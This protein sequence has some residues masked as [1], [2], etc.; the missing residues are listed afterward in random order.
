MSLAG[1]YEVL[2]T[3]NIIS[4]T[5]IATGSE[6]SLAIE[7]SHK[8]ATDGIYSKVISMPCQELFDQQ[9]EIYKNKILN[10]T[11][12]VISIE[13]S[14]TGYWKKYT[15]SKGLNFGID[16]FGASA[17][18]KDVFHKFGLTPKK[19]SSSIRKRIK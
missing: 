11:K 16:D 10:E 13:A 7:V 3:N 5:I 17:P 4:T 8:L 18:A 12:L 19:I 6:T 9:S 14:E 1:A 2:R 15:G